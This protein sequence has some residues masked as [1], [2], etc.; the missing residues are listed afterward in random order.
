VSKTICFIGGPR[1]G[2]EEAL[3]I[4]RNAGLAPRRLD[5]DP[6]AV[7]ELATE[8]PLAILV[9]DEVEDRKE[10]ISFVHEQGELA[11]VPVIIQVPAADPDVVERAFLDG[12]DDYLVDGSY[13]QFTALVATLQSADTWSVVRA[14]NGLVLLAE[15]DR[16]ERVRLGR[17]LKRNGFDTHFAADITE[18]EQSLGSFSPRAVVA[19]AGLPG[20][21]LLEALSKG[22]L[23]IGDGSPWIVLGGGKTVFPGGAGVPE[24]VVFYE[25]GDA[26]RLTFLMNEVL[27]P[28][29][30]NTRKTKRLF[31]G[32][33]V[34]FTPEGSTDVFHGYSYNV[35][36]GGIF[37][38]S[39]TPLPTQVRLSLRFQPPFGRGEVVA[40]GQI[41][42]RREHASTNGQASPSGMGVQ[43]T[44]LAPADRAAFEVG[45]GLLLKEQEAMNLRSRA[46]DPPDDLDDRREVAA[47]RSEM[48]EKMLGEIGLVGTGEP[49]PYTIPN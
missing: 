10:I 17:L 16:Q 34:R 6:G 27:T 19:S 44:S 29:P 46:I 13:A 48:D 14:P 12:A 36:L 5:A 4:L 28:P 32:A 25:G 23:G 41:V 35:N 20:G 38:R 9:G 37:V 31:Y 26:E 42:W 21:S 7:A 22:A 49:V 24:N 40:E 47:P 30:P 2:C 15:E 33:P 3:T 11:R 1:E 8:P 18:L 45:Y 39:L 43:F